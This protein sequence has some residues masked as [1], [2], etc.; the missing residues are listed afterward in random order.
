MAIPIWP[1]R[2][3]VAATLPALVD[4]GQGGQALADLLCFRS[5]KK[6]TTALFAERWE[7]SPDTAARALRRLHAH[8]LLGCLQG[9]GRAARGAHHGGRGSDV[10]F[11]T[12]CGARTISACLGLDPAA[13]VREPI[14]A[15]G[16]PVPTAGG[17][18]K[19][20]AATPQSRTLIAHDLACV[21][22]ALREGCFD[23]D[24]P[25]AM[26]RQLRFTPPYGTTEWAIV[27][28]F[29]I[30]LH[31]TSGPEYLRVE[32]VRTCYVEV[33]G[34]N[35]LPHILEKHHRYAALTRALRHERGGG[36]PYARA[37]ASELTLL[38]VLN[39]APGEERQRRTVLQRHRVAYANRRDGKNYAVAA[40]DLATALAAPAHLPVWRLGAAFDYDKERNRL[41]A[42]W[43]RQPMNADTG[44][45]E[46]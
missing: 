10:W 2:C 13:R 32:E 42:Y 31:H 34:T 17:I 4:D 37:Y 19:Y 8:G 41:R 35:E 36:R 46:R 12:A 33:E 16:A 27:P 14:V 29:A 15:R 30:P 22:L 45:F 20:K 28:D 43:D 23:D 24:T 39:F 9:E 6:W 21:R 11:L 7:T 25:W 40:I 44:D 1:P 26:R 38:L 18:W 5:L 3:D